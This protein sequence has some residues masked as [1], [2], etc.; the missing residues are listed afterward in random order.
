VSASAE[1]RRTRSRAGDS[2]V[3]HRAKWQCQME[4]CLR[5][6]GRAIDPGLRGTAEPWAPSI[7]HIIPLVSGGRD[8]PSN[9]RAAH[10]QCNQEAGPSGTARLPEPGP[11]LTTRIGDLFPGLARLA[12]GE[13]AA[14]GQ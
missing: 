8:I 14:D 5:P 2:L 11:P 13:A 12:S 4:T 7:D 10:R 3:Y 9:K 1:L 6:D